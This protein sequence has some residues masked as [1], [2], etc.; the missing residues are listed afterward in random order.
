[1]GN[2]FSRCTG[3]GTTMSKSEE[4]QWL[5]VSDNDDAF[6]EESMRTQVNTTR[7]N[8]GQ[9]TSAAPRADPSETESIRTSES[10][11]ANFRFTMG[12]NTLPKAAIVILGCAG[13]YVW[14]KHKC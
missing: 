12:F 9:Y 11:V 13:L 8:T 7:T 1:M 5:L 4:E 10:P 14:Y 3:V 6:G 2:K